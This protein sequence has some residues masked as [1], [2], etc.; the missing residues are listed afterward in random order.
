MEELILNCSWKLINQNGIYGCLLTG[1]N[2]SSIF[3]PAAGLIYNSSSDHVGKVGRYYG[4]TPSD[5]SAYTIN[6]GQNL[7]CYVDDYIRYW[8]KSIRP[9]SD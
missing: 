9:V 2:G 8:G 6:F 4:S 1:S 3:L 7:G 5:D